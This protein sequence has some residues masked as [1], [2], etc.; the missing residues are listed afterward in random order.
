MYS[1]TISTW[2]I[3]PICTIQLVTVSLPVYL[4]VTIGGWTLFF[5]TN[6]RAFDPRMRYFLY[7]PNEYIDIYDDLRSKHWLAS[8]A[9]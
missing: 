3:A 1:I 9:A 4:V 5:L 8:A 7:R 2:L 6:V